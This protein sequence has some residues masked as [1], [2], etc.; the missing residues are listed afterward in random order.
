[1]DGGTER[2]LR[3]GVGHGEDFASTRVPFLVS[4]RRRLSRSTNNLCCNTMMGRD[5]SATKNFQVSRRGSPKLRI[6][7]RE[8]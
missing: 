3:W 8:P 7:C 6:N 4:M 1:M 2:K 5:T